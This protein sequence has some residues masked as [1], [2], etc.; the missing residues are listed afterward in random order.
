MT[1]IIETGCLRVIIYKR[2]MERLVLVAD[3]EIEFMLNTAEGT[4]K[5]HQLV[6]ERMKV[7]VGK[8]IVAL[9]AIVVDRSHFDLLLGVIWIK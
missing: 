7:G 3:A 2:C 6:F 4:A 9:P 1:A 8:S 5:K